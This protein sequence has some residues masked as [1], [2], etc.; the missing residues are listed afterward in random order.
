LTGAADRAQAQV[1]NAAR[2]VGQ[3]AQDELPVGRVCHFYT[4]FRA[5]YTVGG[6][7]G[8]LAAQPYDADGGNAA[9]GRDGGNC[10]GHV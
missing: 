10:V 9:A 8:A 1:Q 2:A 3:L 4:A 5:K 7:N 6:G